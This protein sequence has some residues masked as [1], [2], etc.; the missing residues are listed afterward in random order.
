[1]KSLSQV[2]KAYD[3]NYQKILETIKEMGGNE[4]IKAHR[5]D[6]SPLYTKLKDLQHYEHKLDEMENRMMNYQSMIH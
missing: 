2:R 5:S 6:Q 4:C 1:M 3:D